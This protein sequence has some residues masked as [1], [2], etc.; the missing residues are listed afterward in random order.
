MTTNWAWLIAGMVLIIAEFVVPGVYLI[1]FGIAA[2]ITAV[3]ALT[4]DPGLPVELGLFAFS[5]VASVLVGRYFIART[6]MISDDPLLNER[7]ARLI[8]RK[9]IV[10]A[11]IVHG[12]GRVRVGDSEWIATGPDADVGDRVQIVGASGGRLM[13]EA[14]EPE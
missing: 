12:E 1:W 4:V 6:L 9:V 10:T 5:S 2:L 8:G 7:T 11:P 3:V 14:D 13:V